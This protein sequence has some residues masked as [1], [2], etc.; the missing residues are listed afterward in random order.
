MADHGK[1]TSQIADQATQT[2]SDA[3]DT[4]GDIAHDAKATASEAVD[5][6]GKKITA[7]RDRAVQWQAS[8]AKQ[9]AD[10]PIKSVLLAAA[11]GALLAGVL[12]AFDRPSRR[13]L[14]GLRFD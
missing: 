1:I 8:C 2:G 4:A 3:I 13:Y 12:L 9:I 11:G 7:L 5:K 14:H 6:T 10:D